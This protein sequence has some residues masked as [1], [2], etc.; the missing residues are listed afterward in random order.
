ML[1]ELARLSNTD[2][3][4]EQA[5]QVMQVAGFGI[6][7]GMSALGAIGDIRRFDHANELA[8]YSGLCPR[9]R[10]SGQKDER[11]RISKEGE[12]IFDMPLS[13]RQSERFVMTCIGRLSTPD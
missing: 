8:S 4:R 9:Q 2:V 13:R 3:W 1:A 7:H 5:A 12:E 10:Q 6:V 11:G